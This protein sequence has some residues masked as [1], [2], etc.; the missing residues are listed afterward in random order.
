[1]YCAEEI[2]MASPAATLLL[3]VFNVRNCRQT[4]NIP[5]KSGYKDYRK[6]IDFRVEIFPLLASSPTATAE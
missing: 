1:M 6:F 5:E 2:S 4:L 3:S